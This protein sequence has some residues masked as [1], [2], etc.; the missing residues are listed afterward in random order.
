MSNSDLLAAEVLVTTEVSGEEGQAIVE[1]FRALG[2][3]ARTRMVS[4]R[5]GLEQ[6]PWLVLAALPLHASS[7][8]SGPPQR[9]TSPRTLNAWSAEW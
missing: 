9:R 4:T 5:R 8:A 2:V 1:A 3:V 7:A 6:L